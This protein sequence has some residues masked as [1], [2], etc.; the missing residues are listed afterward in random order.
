MFAIDALNQRAYTA[1][2]YSFIGRQISMA[3]EHL[4]FTIPGSPQPKYYAQ[5]K[6]NY[7]PSF[8]CSK[9]G[10]KRFFRL[11]CA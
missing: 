7:A 2:N 10:N 11:L 8:F 5:L 4:P 1:I 9:I 3:A 6:L